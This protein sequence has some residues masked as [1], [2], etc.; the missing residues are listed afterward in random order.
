[1]PLLDELSET[2]CAALAARWREETHDKGALLVSEGD[3]ERDVFFLLQGEVRAAA[4]TLNGREVS[5]S[6]IDTGAC[7]GEI[8]A[9]DKGPRSSSVI[10]LTRVR[11]ARLSS[12]GL[13]AVMDDHPEIAFALLRL[14]MSKLRVLTGKMVDYAELSS[15]Q[16]IKRELARMAR[17][18]RNGLDSAR[19]EAPPNQSELATTVYTRR[20]TVAREMAALRRAGLIAK[21]GGAL[22][23][24][25]IRRLEAE[26]LATSQPAPATL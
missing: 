16:R 23:I 7:F 24:P 11:V 22:V 5:F 10:A 21:D 25:S 3:D 1:M 13:E 14:A 17:S 18:A 8:A 6:L 15:A 12:V 19:I 2:A 20:E 4:F 9:I 26:A